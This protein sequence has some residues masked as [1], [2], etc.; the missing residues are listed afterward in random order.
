MNHGGPAATSGTE[1]NDEPSA[2]VNNV[3]LLFADI[4][5]LQQK[6]N[7]CARSGS[8]EAARACKHPLGEQLCTRTAT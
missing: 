4:A 5:R 8:A 7:I 3:W 6:L 2:S 1:P